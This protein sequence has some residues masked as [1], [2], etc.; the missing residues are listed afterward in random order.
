MRIT[1]L[2]RATYVVGVETPTGKYKLFQIIRRKDG[3]LLV[4]FP[5]Y[6]NE[7]AQLIEGKLKANETYPKVQ[8]IEGVEDWAAT[9]QK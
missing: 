6:S 9:V 2:S 1:A 4:P 8:Q 5:Y 7:S 3:S